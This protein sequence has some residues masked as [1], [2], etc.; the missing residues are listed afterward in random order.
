M[1]RSEFSPEVAGSGVERDPAC[2]VDIV[3]GFRG[4]LVGCGEEQGAYK[5]VAPER[6]AESCNDNV[7]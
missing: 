6:A 3:S 4:I 1:F 2:Q 5:S 7:T